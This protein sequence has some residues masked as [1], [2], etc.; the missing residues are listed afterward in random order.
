[1]CDLQRSSTF[2]TDVSPPA[3]YGTTRIVLDPNAIGPQNVSTGF[4]FVRSFPA[5]PRYGAAWSRD[6]ARMGYL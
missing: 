2:R 1:L 4:C 3:A 5:A 6:D